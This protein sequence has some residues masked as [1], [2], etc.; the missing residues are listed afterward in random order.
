LGVLPVDSVPK[1][2]FPIQRLGD[3]KQAIDAITSIRAGG[4][5]IYVYS[6]LREAYRE[7]QDI[8]A[9]VKHVILFADTAD[10]EEKEGANGESSLALAQRALEK[11]QI[12]TTTIGIGQK[13][14]S[15][16]EFLQQVAT[17]ANGRFYFTNDMY[18]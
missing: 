6:G 14:D 2:A 17:I 4:G 7:L 10:C 12:T 11:Y 5:G 13:G 1:W 15:D 3:K 16:V 8:K 9:S 18:T